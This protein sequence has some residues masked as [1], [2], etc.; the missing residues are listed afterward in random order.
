MADMMSRFDRSECAGVMAGVFWWSSSDKQ[1]RVVRRWRVG[2]VCAVI[3]SGEAC[4]GVLEMVRGSE[5]QG[6]YS[7]SAAVV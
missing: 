2:T 5:E 3:A 1:R 4:V 7:R 6:K